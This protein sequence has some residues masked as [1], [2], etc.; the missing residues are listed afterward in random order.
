MEKLS[1]PYILKS[2]I[3]CRATGKEAVRYLS[4]RIEKERVAEIRFCRTQ[5]MAL[6]YEVYIIPKDKKDSR[7]STS[8][9]NLESCAFNLRMLEEYLGGRTI[10]NPLPEI[11]VIKE[12]DWY[13]SR[14]NAYMIF[15]QA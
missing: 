8:G 1:S 6:R 14:S 13:T 10:G 9:F 7:P 12:G 5:P 3:G 2:N 4:N 15:V 11:R